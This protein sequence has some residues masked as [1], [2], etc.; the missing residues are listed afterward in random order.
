MALFISMTG[1]DI[2]HVPYKGGAPQV[3]ALVAGE[4]QASL[5]TVS[6][7]IQHLRAG[8]LRPLGVNSQKRVG[9]LPDTP[10]IA[11]SGVVG[12]EMSPWIGVFAPA[13]TPKP[14]IDRLHAAIG[15]I[16]RLP[17]VTQNLSNQALEPSVASVDQFNATIKADYEKYGKLIR[18]AGARLE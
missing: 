17:E 12:Y 13:G 3:T 10:T 14:V 11:E 2:V 5:A 15:K 16:L 18:L 6:T 7:V 8:K 9:V 1:I 4:A